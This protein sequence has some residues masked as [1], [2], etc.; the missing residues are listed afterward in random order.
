MRGHHG[1]NLQL[2]MKGLFTCF[3]LGKKYSLQFFNQFKS[4]LST[5][6]PSNF[7][8]STVHGNAV[9]TIQSGHG[10]EAGLNRGNA[11]QAIL[12]QTEK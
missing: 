2:K 1:Q 12:L 4:L 10:S 5:A 7:E 6:K 8:Q 9:V 11:T 3:L